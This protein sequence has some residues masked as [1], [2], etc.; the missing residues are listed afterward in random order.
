MIVN[1]AASWSM[2]TKNE[3]TAIATLPLLAPLTFLVC[4]LLARTLVP[5][6]P[7]RRG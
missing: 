7:G 6:G 4:L 3:A 2:M 5:A 1:R